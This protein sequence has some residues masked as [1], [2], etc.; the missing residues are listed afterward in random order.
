MNISYTHQIKESRIILRYLW[1]NHYYQVEEEEIIH[2]LSRVS[3]ATGVTASEGSTY[4]N[5]PTL[6][7]TPEILPQAE[8]P[9]LPNHFALGLHIPTELPSQSRSTDF[10][11]QVITNFNQPIPAAYLTVDQV[12]A[13]I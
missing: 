1:P 9:V 10:T 12:L 5:T 3:L 4:T 7:S 8:L 2:A 6:P 13:H 11:Q